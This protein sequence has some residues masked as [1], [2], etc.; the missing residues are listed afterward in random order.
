VYDEIKPLVNGGV[1]STL[2]RLKIIDLLM[3]PAAPQPENS[4]ITPKPSHYSAVAGAGRI[5]KMDL[6]DEDCGDV[7]AD[8]IMH[9]GSKTTTSMVGDGTSNT[10]LLGDRLYVFENW[11]SG[12]TKFGSPPDQICVGAAQ[13][14]RYRVNADP[15]EVGYYVGDREAPDGAPKT[16]LLNDLAFAS[17]HAGGAQFAF[18]DGSVRML[19]ESIDFDLFQDLATMDGGET[20]AAP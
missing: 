11:L 14:V 15:S 6:E 8:G 5:A 20:S 10:L 3:C 12:A 2:P 18:G 19:N 16:A 17:D 4:P 13:N 1:T 7:D 9:P